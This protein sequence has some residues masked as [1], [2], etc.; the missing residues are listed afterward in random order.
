MSGLLQKDYCLLRQRSRS[1][2]V[3]ACV[4]LMIGFSTD[5]SF[6]VGYM[7]MM[8]A[9]LTIGTI[10]YDEFDNGYPFLLTLPVSRK[11]YV[12]EKYLFCLAG[13]AV[14]WIVSLLLYAVCSVAKG[15]SLS[16]VDLVQT[17]AFLPVFCL[18]VAVML[19]MQL[20]YGAEKSRIAIA[21]LGGGGYALI[22][23]GMKL[24]PRNMQIPAS[25]SHL[26]DFTIAVL[27]LVLS[28]SALAISYLC[29]LRIFNRKA[30]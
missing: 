18:I 30:F 26:S 7:T 21:V 12:Q 25:V 9:L 28:L 3:L 20:K 17:V 5:G 1:L 2:I 19:P 13:G 16:P 11:L 6:V 4:G 29:S 24:L 27:F 14:G 8:V 15:D 10:S 23:F 22:F